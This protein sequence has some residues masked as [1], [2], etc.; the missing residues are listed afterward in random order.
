MD[1]WRGEPTKE[2]RPRSRVVT[3]ALEGEGEE[4]IGTATG[5]VVDSSLG[6]DMLECVLGEGLEIYSWSVVSSISLHAE[7]DCR[8][9]VCKVSVSR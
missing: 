6:L 4:P 3:D 8:C 2:E 7:L 1:A 5:R 9:E